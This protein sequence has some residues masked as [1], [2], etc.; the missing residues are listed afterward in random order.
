MAPTNSVQSQKGEMIKL[1]GDV[2]RI[3]HHPLNIINGVKL[4]V[5]RM[6][7]THSMHRDV[8]GCTNRLSIKP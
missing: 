1:R 5:K 4:K 3:Q 6:S 7:N 8:K 2:F